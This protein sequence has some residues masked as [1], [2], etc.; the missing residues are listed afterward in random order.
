VQTEGV[1]GTPNVEMTE[2]NLLPTITAAVVF[3]YND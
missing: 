1:N 3:G 2:I